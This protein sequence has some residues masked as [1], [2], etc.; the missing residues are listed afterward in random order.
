V[1]S[2][3]ALSGSWSSRSSCAQDA[4]STV[5]DLRVVVV[6]GKKA[7]V[8]LGVG[9]RVINGRGADTGPRET[10]GRT[11]QGPSQRG[12]PWLGFPT[13]APGPRLVRPQTAAAFLSCSSSLRYL[14]RSHLFFSVA[15]F[16][17]DIFFFSHTAFA[18]WVPSARLSQRYPLPP[19]TPAPT[20]DDR[21]IAGIAT[22]HNVNGGLSDILRVTGYTQFR[23]I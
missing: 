5:A 23:C 10:S 9:A 19:V 1:S 11:K 14:L 4:T 17:T 12:R 20:S 18:Y 2:S 16:S 7:T 3:S 13:S 22:F 6:V 21:H 8:G 15:P